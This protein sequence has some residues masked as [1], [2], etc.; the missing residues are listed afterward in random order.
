MK[1]MKIINW[2]KM[3]FYAP[4]RNKA[5]AKMSYH[6][7]FAKYLE[8]KTVKKRSSRQQAT[9]DFNYHVA[10]SWQLTLEQLDLKISKPDIE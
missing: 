5:S 10:D 4:Q 2:F 9:I 1:T 6:R 3:E 8:E 7:D